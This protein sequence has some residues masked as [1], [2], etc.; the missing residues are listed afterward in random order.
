MLIQDELLSMLIWQIF[1]GKNTSLG[2]E[3]VRVE[4]KEIIP[5]K[6]VQETMNMVIKAENEKRSAIDFA[7]AKETE[8]DGLRRA[9]IKESEVSVS[10]LF[11]KPKVGGR[12]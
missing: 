9:S 3:V 4:L 7:T 10:Q 5:P 11:W 1:C 6:D 8:A 12:Q 2:S